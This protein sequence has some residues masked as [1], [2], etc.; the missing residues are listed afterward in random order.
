MK[1][2]QGGVALEKV[3]NAPKRQRNNGARARKRK[4]WRNNANGGPKRDRDNTSTPMHPSDEG[5]MTREQKTKAL[6]K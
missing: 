1:D 6:E 5:T 4:L 3:S 2:R